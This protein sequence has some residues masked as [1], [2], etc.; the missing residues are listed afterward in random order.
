MAYLNPAEWDKYE[1]I[2]I[3]HQG[4]A[5][6]L[7]RS[8]LAN[9]TEKNCHA[10]YACGHLV[11]KTAFASPQLRQSL[12]LSSSVGGVSEAFSLIRGAWAIHQYA[13]EWLS[14]GP[15]GFCLERALDENPDFDLYPDDPYL[16]RLLSVLLVSGGQEEDVHICCGAV[17]LLRKLFAMTATPGQ[18]MSIKT[19]AYSWPAQLPDRYFVLVGDLM[20]QALVV[21][22]H[23]TVLMK[24]IG[25]F[26]YMDGCAEGI[27]KQC[28]QNLDGKWLRHIEWPLSIVSAD[29]TQSGSSG[30]LK[31]PS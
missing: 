17:N 21:L 31:H 27:M 30:T 18:T 10:I 16:A 7:F 14:A 20:P 28:R 19:I 2:A 12:F 24:M 3:H 1:M 25:H 6:P 13:F 26:W 29:S 5:L 4:L 9:V 22:A 23:Y 15:L 8:S 11:A